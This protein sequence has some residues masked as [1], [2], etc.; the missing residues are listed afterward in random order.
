MQVFLDHINLKK[1]Y[2]QSKMGKGKETSTGVSVYINNMRG[3]WA[4]DI[5][6]PKANIHRT[7]VNLQ[8]PPSIPCT[9]R[10]H[11]VPKTPRK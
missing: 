10:E 4:H 6:I 1:T 9:E 7:I 3:V 5:S 8:F 11:S 2:M